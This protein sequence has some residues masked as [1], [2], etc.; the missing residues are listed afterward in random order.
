L[1]FPVSGRSQRRGTTWLIAAVICAVAAILARETA[2]VAPLLWLWW[3]CMRQDRVTPPLSAPRL[4]A[5]VPAMTPAYAL[6]LSACAW[7]LLHDRYAAL[8]DLSRQIAAMR[9]TEPSLIGA[10]AYFAE[11]FVLLRYPTIDPAF[12]PG[13]WPTVTRMLATLAV[14]SV[15]PVAWCLRHR[16]P[17]LLFGCGWVLLWLAPIYLFRIRHDPVAEH[18][19]YPAVWGFALLAA[20]TWADW[21]EHIGARRLGDAPAVVIAILLAAAT[22]VRNTDY[23]SEIDLWEA[24]A[25]SAPDKPRV[26]NNLGAAYLGASRWPDAAAA[27]EQAL[28]LDP[29][30]D[31]ARCNLY[32]AQRRET[33]PRRGSCMPP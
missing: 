3:K 31:R 22:V 8:L 18:H 20:A 29:S 13:Q 26:L 1:R 17:Q 4:K 24:A 33:E 19:F 15:A 25:R 9:W 14:A 16:A 5:I 21:R 23:R 28:A 10:L 12:A 30:L 32:A 11:G 27:F 2:I 6:I 7:L